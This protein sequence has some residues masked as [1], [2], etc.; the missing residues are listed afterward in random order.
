M[1]KRNG[2]GVF[3]ND[4]S[5]CA[6][7]WGEPRLTC[8]KIEKLGGHTTPRCG[9]TEGFVRV[10]AAGQVNRIQRYAPERGIV[11]LSGKIKKPIKI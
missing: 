1:G 4:V 3:K 10:N 8:W 11:G 5:L 2:C 9:G 7:P 6:L